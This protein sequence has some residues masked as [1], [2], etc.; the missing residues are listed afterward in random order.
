[1]TADG[2][3]YTLDEAVAEL[4]RREC[5]MHGHSWTVIETPAGP[6]GLICECGEKHAIADP[7]CPCHDPI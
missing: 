7:R 5:R 1:M 2:Q 3:T 6:V 4:R